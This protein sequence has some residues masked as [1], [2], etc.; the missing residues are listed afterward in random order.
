MVLERLDQVGGGAPVAAQLHMLAVLC[1]EPFEPCASWVVDDFEA[2]AFT[3]DERVPPVLLLAG[4]QRFEGLR[5]VEPDIALAIRDPL[6]TGCQNLR[7]VVGRILELGMNVTGRPRRS[8]NHLR[9]SVSA[10][11]CISPDIS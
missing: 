2:V 1:G 9:R 3:L 11:F 6:K 10:S 4:P 5:Q 8:R 7:A